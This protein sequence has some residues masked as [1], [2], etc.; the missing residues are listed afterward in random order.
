MA[1]AKLRAK[2]ASVA[3]CTIG[4]EIGTRNLKRSHR[5]RPAGVATH[6]PKPAQTPSKASSRTHQYA[7]QKLENPISHCVMVG[8]FAPN[9][10]YTLANCGM[11]NRLMMPNAMP[12][13][14]TT[15]MG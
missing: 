10:S 1:S 4:P 7:T 14:T 13:T 8:S 6:A 2:R 9:P 15:K 12:I 3:F 5:W 11:T